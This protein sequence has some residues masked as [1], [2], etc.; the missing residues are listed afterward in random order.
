MQFV[1]DMRQ[2]ENGSGYISLARDCGSGS[3]SCASSSI[4]SGSESL[5]SPKSGSQMLLKAYK[6]YKAPAEG[7]ARERDSPGQEEK[8]RLERIESAMKEER[9]VWS[10]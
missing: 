6:D 7:E 3:L 4:F 9:C 2:E 10:M 5:G 1:V 8:E